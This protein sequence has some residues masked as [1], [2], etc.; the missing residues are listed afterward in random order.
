MAIVLK[1]LLRIR[2]LLEEASRADLERRVIESARVEAAVRR[3]E[4]AVRR[5]RGEGLAPLLA[6]G[7]SNVAPSRAETEGQSRNRYLAEKELRASQPVRERLEWMA[8]QEA[9]RMLA[10]REEFLARRKERRQ[11]ELLL[12]AENQRRRVEEARRD[13]RT[14]DDWFAAGRTRLGRAGKKG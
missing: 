10:S 3:Q 8:K 2:S 6:S 4:D 1:R 13:Q 5:L 9:R 14:L 12:Q 11:V 7:G